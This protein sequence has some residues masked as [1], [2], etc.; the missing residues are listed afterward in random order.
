[1][2]SILNFFRNL[3]RSFGSGRSREASTGTGLQPRPLPVVLRVRNGN[4]GSPR[5][6]RR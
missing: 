2:S 4:E 6:R 1:M 5:G 3:A